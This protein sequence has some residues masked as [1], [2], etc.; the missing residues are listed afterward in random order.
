ML[1][2]LR[3]RLSS[4]VRSTSIFLCVSTYSRKAGHASKSFSWLIETVADSPSPSV[5]SRRSLTNRST[6]F[7]AFEFYFVA[8]GLY[9]SMA[10]GMRLLLH[11]IYWAI[12]ERARPAERAWSR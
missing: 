7:R 3:A 12:F 8:T 2:H 11:A 6:T 5:L 1:T 10:I 9:L 4:S